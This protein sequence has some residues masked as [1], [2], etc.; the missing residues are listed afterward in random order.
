M[1]ILP[2]WIMDRIK[3]QMRLRPA[4]WEVII[5][6]NEK[7]ETPESLPWE[8]NCRPAQELTSGKPP[9]AAVPI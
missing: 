3:E 7:A 6:A 5:A 4:A 2:M 8:V 9:M 1:A